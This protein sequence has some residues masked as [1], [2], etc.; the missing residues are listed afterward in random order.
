MLC[1]VQNSKYLCLVMKF[2]RKNHVICV[3]K[4][5]VKIVGTSFYRSLDIF[6][7]SYAMLDNWYQNF[8]YQIV[9]QSDLNFNNDLNQVF[10]KK[11]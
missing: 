3:L 6:S 10:I 2:T 11:I 1:S 7:Q 9:I 8:L 4:F 5:I